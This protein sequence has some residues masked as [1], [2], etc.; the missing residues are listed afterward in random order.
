MTI[1]RIGLD[2]AK[3][4]FQLHGVDARGKTVLRKT[5]ARGEVLGFFANRPACLIGIEACAGSHYWARELIRLGHDVRLMAAQF[6]IPYRKSGKND[7]TDAEAI[8]EAVG[9]P[10]MRFVPVK[11]EEAQAVL[12]V[13]RARALTVSER[14]ALVNQVR[15]L[16]GEF[17]I[18]A[19]AGIAHA[20][21]LLAEIGAG[22]RS[23][24]V[25][26]R[27][28]FG[29]LHD[30]L[31]ALDERILA[32]DRKISTLAQQSEAARR[33]MAIE[34]IGPV[35]AS[36]IVASVGPATTF[37]SGR[38]F[39]A[40]LGLTPRQHSSGGKTVLG[41]ISKRGDVVLRTLLI[42]G[43]RSVLRLT[44][45]QSD[46]KSQWVERLK[47]RSCNNVAAVALAAKNARIIWAMLT[48]GTDYR[49]AATATA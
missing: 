40:W 38:Q 15:G 28:T 8:C 10:N 17:G 23:L 29:E 26:A 43:A 14:T 31:R 25:L 49:V 35:T 12:A 9:R 33:L 32:Y 30:R 3:S 24:P 16:L 47:A 20:R 5:L 34:G 6:V 4:V 21:T 22:A 45:A 41:G 37:S 7:A 48:R 19:R 39:A 44:A 42:H 1:T 11:S 36:A 18:V 2:I 46:R 27:E 13:H